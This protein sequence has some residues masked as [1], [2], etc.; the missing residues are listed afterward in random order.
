PNH[1]QAPGSYMKPFLK[2]ALRQ[3][4][5]F[6]PVQ[7]TGDFTSPTTLLSKAPLDTDT[8]DCG[9]HYEKLDYVWSTRNLSSSLLLGDGVAVGIYGATGTTLQPGSKFIS[10][11][12]P[13]NL[14]RLVRY[15]AVQEFTIFWGT[16]AA[17]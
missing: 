17:T 2:Q 3:K 7:V 14:N 10:E 11:G 8:I 15:Q 1:G 16:T 13:V 12:S 6:P 5:T 4:T 9:Y